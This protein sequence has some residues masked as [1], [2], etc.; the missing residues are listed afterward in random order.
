MIARFPSDLVEQVSCRAEFRN[1]Q[2]PVEFTRDGGLVLVERI[3]TEAR[4]PTGYI[5]LVS[6]TEHETYT[7][8]FDL[9]HQTWRVAPF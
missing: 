8:E 2:R 6:T 3:V 1:P 4:T 7:L 5:F 9:G